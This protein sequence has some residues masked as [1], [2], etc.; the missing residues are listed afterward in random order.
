[1]AQLMRRRLPLGT[2]PRWRGEEAT[3]ATAPASISGHRWRRMEQWLNG[4]EGRR[5]SHQFLIRWYEMNKQHQLLLLCLGRME[6]MSYACMPSDLLGER[7]EER[8]RELEAAS[9]HPPVMSG[10]WIGTVPSIVVVVFAKEKY[11]PSH[12][13]LLTTTFVH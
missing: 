10:V 12:K 5:S 8:E 4:E 6:D 2:Y 7:G 3:V 11:H 1:M 9:I 13:I